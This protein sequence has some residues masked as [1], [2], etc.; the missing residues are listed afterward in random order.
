MNCPKC[1]AVNENG[2]KYCRSCGTEIISN[3]KSALIERLCNRV[4]RRKILTFIML[5]IFNVIAVIVTAG[6]II[7]IG[8]ILSEMGGRNYAAL[9]VGFGIILGIMMLIVNIIVLSFLKSLTD[10]FVE[11]NMPNK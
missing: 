5:H 3:N 2:A 8:V 4:N 6:T 7:G 1:G 9:F 10:L 11:T